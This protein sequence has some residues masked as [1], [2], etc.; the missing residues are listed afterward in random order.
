M[1]RMA[2]S[3]P[4]LCIKL[5]MI[6]LRNLVL[7]LKTVRYFLAGEK[8]LFKIREPFCNNLYKSGTDKIVSS[9]KK[10]FILK[11]IRIQSIYYGTH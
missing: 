10:K 7:I 5:M 4:I 11:F 8:L 1:P 3:V 2:E 6:H 9:F